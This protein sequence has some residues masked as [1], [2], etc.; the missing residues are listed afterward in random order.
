MHGMPTRR[1][2]PETLS[3]NGSY[4]SSTTS[5][6]GSA[7][8]AGGAR[9]GG[10]NASAGWGRNTDET[11]RTE[12]ESDTRRVTGLLG[13]PC[14]AWYALEKELT[15]LTFERRVELVLIFRG[16]GALP[17]TADGVGTDGV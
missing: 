4:S 12:P 3:V 17:L 1:D 2:T 13:L 5:S 9:G 8:A 11:E 7:G 15:E 14:A 16:G 6:L 10:S